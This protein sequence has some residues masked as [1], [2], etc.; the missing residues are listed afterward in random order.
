MG[1]L[2]C[3]HSGESRNPFSCMEKYPAV[4]LL[5]NKKR[6]TLYIAV[7]SDLVGRV[8]EHKTNVIEGF[9]KRYEIHRLVWYERHETM[10]SAINREKA[11]KRWKRAWKLELVEKQNPDWYDTII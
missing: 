4:Y 5:A 9:T 11:L 2:F 8:W 1:R 6:G 7:T 3:R 10:E